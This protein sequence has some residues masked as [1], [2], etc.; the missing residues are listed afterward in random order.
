M[1]LFIRERADLR[2]TQEEYLR[3]TAEADQWVQKALDTKRMKAAQNATPLRIRV[4]SVQAGKLIR[5]VDP[6]YPSLALQ[7]RIQG[8]VKLHLTIAKDGTTQNIMVI[9][10]H[11]LLVPAALE[12]VKQWVYEPT[13]LNGEP[14]AVVD[15]VEI[16]FSLP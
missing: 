1:N 12:A 7:A 6:V 15:E 14:E 11:P 10:G 16:P 8:V 3:D 9:S 4:G 2:D 5:R 13:L